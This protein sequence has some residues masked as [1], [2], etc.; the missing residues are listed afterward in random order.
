MEITSKP[1]VAWETFD[2]VRALTVLQAQNIDNRPIRQ[3]R[4]Q[5]F[6]DDMRAG[7]WVGLNGEPLQFDV[8]GILRNGQHRLWAVVESGV[9]LE[10]LVV[11]GISATAYD[12]IDT[13]APKSYTDFL[14]LPSVG[15]KNV[16]LLA[17][18]LKLVSL[19]ERGALRHIKNGHY[20]P[21]IPMMQE[22]LRRRPEIRDVVSDIAGMTALK[23]VLPLSLAALVY[24][25]ASID[26]QRDK[27][28]AF[29]DQ[30]AT[31]LNMTV[32]TPAYHFKRLLDKQRGSKHKVVQTYMLALFIKC[33]NATKEGKE[34]KVLR[35]SADEEF[36]TL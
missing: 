6:A 14:G 29:L 22:L 35:L 26:G 21:T 32:T 31:G 24:F 20:F 18:T 2:T 10:A 19:W 28:V 36:P 11:R 7:R 8:N 16:T 9:N 12:T 25:V 3:D 27:V 1:T 17:S 5:R 30:I 13:G 4:V 33:W 23:G 34:M 15:E